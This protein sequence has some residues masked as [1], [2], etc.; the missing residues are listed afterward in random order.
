MLGIVQLAG[1]L[2]GL[3]VSLLA[4]LLG[5][6]RCLAAGLVLMAVGSAGGALAWSAPPLMVS[7]AVEGAG[8]ILVAVTGPGLIKRN[9]PAPRLHAS[10]GF[11]GAYHGIS[12]YT[13]PWIAVVGFLPTVY[14]DSGMTGIWPGLLSAVVGGAGA[15]GSLIAAGR[16]TGHAAAHGRG[17][18]TRARLRRGGRRP[19]PQP[20]RTPPGTPSGLTGER[21]ALAV[22][23]GRGTRGP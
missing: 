21:A 14:R 5:E 1:M 11:W 8:F 7:R 12:C 23:T 19:Q 16:D 15:V 10:M 20:Q 9:T 2:G 18:D 3:A 17:T 22:R 6:R 4:E 13:L